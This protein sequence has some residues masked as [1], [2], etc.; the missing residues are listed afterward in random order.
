MIKRGPGS[1]INTV[2]PLLILELKLDNLE[3]K[4]VLHRAKELLGGRSAGEQR[5]VIA[6]VIGSLSTNVEGGTRVAMTM[7]F[8]NLTGYPENF[9]Y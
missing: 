5:R 7:A 9:H 4:R 8:A 2:D 6:H 1:S 3:H